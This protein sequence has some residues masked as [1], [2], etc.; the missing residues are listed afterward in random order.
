[1]SGITGEQIGTTQTVEGSGIA[2]VEWNGL[3]EGN[4]YSWYAVIKDKSG[5]EMMT[6]MQSFTVPKVEIDSVSF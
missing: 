5:N 1:M 4:T 3:E 2:S 6:D